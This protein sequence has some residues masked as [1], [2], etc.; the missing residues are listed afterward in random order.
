MCK[1]WDGLHIRPLRGEAYASLHLTYRVAERSNSSVAY[2]TSIPYTLL[3]GLV[4]CDPHG[5]LR[6]GVPWYA[7]ERIWLFVT[8][9]HIQTPAMVPLNSIESDH[10]NPKNIF[11]YRSRDV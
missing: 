8:T 5:L 7:A 4:I 11:L 10:N 3:G 6:T 1:D 2:G 9:G